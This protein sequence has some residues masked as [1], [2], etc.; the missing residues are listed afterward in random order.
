MATPVIEDRELQV[1]AALA[2]AVAALSIGRPRLL[3]RLLL[4]DPDEVG[5]PLVGDHLESRQ[6]SCP[7]RRPPALFDRP[8][9]G[10]CHDPV[11]R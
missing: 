4:L 9:T 1:M 7:L 2:T 8:R 11:T 6:T 5:D 3:A 10:P